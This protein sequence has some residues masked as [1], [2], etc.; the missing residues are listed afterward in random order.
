LGGFGL[1]NNFTA[2]SKQNSEYFLKRTVLKKESV[3]LSISCFHFIASEKEPQKGVSHSTVRSDWKQDPNTSPPS[4]ASCAC[5]AVK[6]FCS[7]L[8]LSSEI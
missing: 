3:P 4:F 8:P 5:L 1:E 7:G 2:M 6:K